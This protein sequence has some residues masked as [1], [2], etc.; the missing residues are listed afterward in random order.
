MTYIL[1]ELV[2]E[3]KLLK[4]SLEEKRTLETMLENCFRWE[5]EACSLLQHADYLFDFRN[6]DDGMRD[7]L[8]SKIEGLLLSLD[9]MI[10]DGLSLG[11][12]FSETKKLQNAHSALQWCIKV[13]QF[14]S[15]SPSVEVSSLFF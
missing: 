11:F 9:A 4:I 8:T 14:S 1:Q 3:S 6:V 13:L 15:I 10:K 5:H 7:S 2:S 12:D